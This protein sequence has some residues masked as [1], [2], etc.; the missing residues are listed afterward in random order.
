MTAGLWGEPPRAQ[1]R[2][3]TATNRTLIQQLLAR[4]DGPL[5]D[6][7]K[8]WNAAAYAAGVA[9]LPTGM[10]VPLRNP[11]PVAGGTGA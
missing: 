5:L 2:A 3:L 8:A 6:K 1:I 4:Y 11:R 10:A 9:T 7:V